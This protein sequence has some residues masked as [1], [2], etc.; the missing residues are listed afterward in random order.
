MIRKQNGFKSLFKA[1]IKPEDLQPGSAK[2]K[3][4]L[5]G[6]PQVKIIAV[7]PETVTLKI[8]A[9]RKLKIKP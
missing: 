7:K 1:R 6:P 3:V 5:E 8:S 4:F 2:L 9:T